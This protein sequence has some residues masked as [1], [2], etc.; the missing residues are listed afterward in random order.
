[1]AKKFDLDSLFVRGDSRSE[2]LEKYEKA[3]TANSALTYRER[4]KEVALREHGNKFKGSKQSRFDALGRLMSETM[5]ELE[6]ELGRQPTAREVWQ[7]LPYQEERAGCLI[8]DRENEGFEYDR[9]WWLTNGRE[10]TTDFR[11]FQKRIT[12][13]RKTLRHK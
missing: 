8:Q 10:K 6:Q 9:L 12:H 11:A 4:D 1:M 3:V 13:L 7:S 5:Q 2:A